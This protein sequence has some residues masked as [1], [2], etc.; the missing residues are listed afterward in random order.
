[1]Q[2]II[3]CSALMGIAYALGLYF[4]DVKQAKEK[5][6]DLELAKAHNEKYITITSEHQGKRVIVDG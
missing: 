5:N 2:T 4:R 1:M 6:K 3:M